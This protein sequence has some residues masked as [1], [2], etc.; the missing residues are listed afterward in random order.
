M[1]MN[2]GEIPKEH[3]TQDAEIGGGRIIGEACHY[4]DLMRFLAGSKIKSFNAVKMGE[5]DFVEVTE[6]KA[7][8]SLTFEDGSM[9]SI[10][11]FANGG[12]VFSQRAYRGFL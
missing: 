2:A 9:G 5:N 11:Y 8:I 6:D 1:T 3:W 12:K 7:L 10:H 4:I